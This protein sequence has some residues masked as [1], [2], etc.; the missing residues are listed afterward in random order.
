MKQQVLIIFFFVLVFNS[1]A[2]NYSSFDELKANIVSKTIPIISVEEL[3]KVENTTTPLL[4]LD[5]REQSEFNVSHIKNAKYIGYDHFKIN[6]LKDIDKE[7]TVIVYC[8]VGYRSEKIG[9]KTK[10]SRI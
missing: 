10:K 2:Q 7:T 8:S 9:G 5:A 4:I 6:E 1:N 3:K